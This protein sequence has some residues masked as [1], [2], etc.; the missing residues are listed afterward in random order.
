MSARYD[1]SGIRLY[2]S[3]LL[4]CEAMVSAVR[5][6]REQPPE[7]LVDAL[8]L[9]ATNC[10]Y[11]AGEGKEGEDFVFPDRSS[12]EEAP[13]TWREC[14]IDIEMVEN[15][16]ARFYKSKTRK[17]RLSAFRKKQILDAVRAEVQGRKPADNVALVEDMDNKP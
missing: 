5:K 7:W 9:A 11:L 8:R 15:T 16:L 4:F 17:S 14:V 10:R 6:Q 3:S 13:M 1:Q 2:A 12:R